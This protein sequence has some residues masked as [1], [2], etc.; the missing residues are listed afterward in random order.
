[1]RRLLLTM[2]VAAPPLAAQRV[3]GVRDVARAV[4]AT[5]DSLTTEYAVEG[6]R[7]I[8]RRSLA[9]DVV[10]A[11]LY[12]LGGTRSP[13]G[14][15]VE[16]FLLAVSERGTQQYPRERLT[17]AM[18]RTGAAVVV[19]P[20]KDWT[21]IGLRATVTTVDSAWAVFADR[22]VAPRLADADVEF[23]RAQLLNAVAQRRDDPDAGL[24]HLADSVGFAG[25]P[26]ARDLIGDDG[27]VRRV[28]GRALREAHRA[29]FVRSRMLLVVVGAIPRAQV[30]RLVRGTLAQLPAGDHQWAMPDTLPRAGPALAIEARALPTN[31]LKGIFAGPRADSPDYAP[32]RVASAVL[33]GRLFGEIRSRR[34]L[35]YAVSAD[36]TEEAASYGTL[37]VT[38]NEPRLVLQLMQQ[39]VRRLQAERVDAAGL[40]TLIQQ[41]LTQ[42]WMDNETNAEQADLLARAAL[43]RGDYRAV[44]RTAADLLAVTPADIQRVAR[45]YFRDVRWAY[46]GDPTRIGPEAVRG[47]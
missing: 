24:D 14:A 27:A 8:H 40:P 30:E 44:Q 6:L 47:F 15:G 31:Y 9:N 36:L 11:N 2:L 18:A 29:T 38:T 1:M 16:P 37:Y 13:A 42:Y 45:R 5:E 34:N 7:V 43:F 25:H 22:V 32:M 12:L 39:E 4:P 23:V 3:G 17:R 46:L 28:T 41:F 19:T 33:S 10:V 20:A 21:M 26:Y 35:T